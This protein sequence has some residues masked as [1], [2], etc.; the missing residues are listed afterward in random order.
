MKKLRPAVLTCP[1]IHSGARIPT[2]EVHVL[3]HSAQAGIERIYSKLF[4]KVLLVWLF[5]VSFSW[6]VD[7]E[8]C[9]LVSETYK[10]KDTLRKFNSKMLMLLSLLINN[11]TQPRQKLMCVGAFQ[12]HQVW[13]FT[14]R[15]HRTQHVNTLMVKIYYSRR[16]QSRI[17]HGE[18]H[19]EDIQEKT[20][21]SSQRPR[22]VESHSI[23]PAVS[24][25]NTCERLSV[26]ETQTQ[27][28][29]FLLGAHPL[30]IAH[31]KIPD[32][33]KGGKFSG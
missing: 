10:H 17:S 24:C 28:A 31:T 20:G 13:W 9:K 21:T 22:P 5:L 16:V 23:T 30:G 6:R 19:I 1:K 14:R 8:N 25:D 15:T 27:S 29:K 12:A 32:S 26:R 33:Q 11:S 7:I 18:R 3:T 2:W 4:K